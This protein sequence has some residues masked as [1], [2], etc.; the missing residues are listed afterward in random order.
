V[1][2]PSELGTL[3]FVGNELAAFTQAG[4]MALTFGTIVQGLV[5]NLL[6]VTP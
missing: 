5:A 6:P 4:G 3:G 2:L 1:D